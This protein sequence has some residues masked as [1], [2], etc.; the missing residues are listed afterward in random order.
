MKI[1]F[2]SKF[3]LIIFAVLLVGAWMLMSNAEKP[4]KR[5]EIELL[6]STT[7]YYIYPTGATAY[8]SDTI[9][10]S[11]NDTLYLGSNLISN[12]TYNWHINT[13][14]LTGTQSIIAIVQETNNASAS[15][16]TPTDW[17]EVAR[18]TFAANEDR[19]I[20]GATIY[21]IKQ[22]LILDGSGTQSATYSV[23]FAAKKD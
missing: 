19:R 5:E 2:S 14:Q 8:I 12:W 17:L 6:A 16:T 11:E 23:K 22:R 1:L 20:V 9:T 15:Q 10:D 13:T 7:P 18:D 21:G 3:N 4:Q